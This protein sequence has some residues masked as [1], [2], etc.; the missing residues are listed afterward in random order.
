MINFKLTVDMNVQSQLIVFTLDSGHLIMDYFEL[1]YFANKLEFSVEKYPLQPD[2]N[3]SINVIAEKDAYVALQAIEQRDLL[4]R[5]EGF[6]ITKAHVLEDLNEYTPD[7]YLIESDPIYYFGLFVR[8]SSNTH[9]EPS[10]TKRSTQRTRCQPSVKHTLSEIDYPESW[11]WKI[12]TMNNQSKLIISEVMPKTITSWFVTGFALSPTRGL[13]LMNA[14]TKLTVSKPFLI[15]AN[16]PY[17]IE[18]FEVVRIQVTLFN[19]L[20]DPL[21]TNVTLYNEC[22][23]F[24]FVDRTSSRAKILVKQAIVK[25]YDHP[26]I[27]SF[28]IK[29]KKLGDITIKIEAA[30]H[31]RTDELKHILR[32]T[33][34]NLLEKFSQTELI[35]L[36]SYATQNFTM[37]IKIPK[38]AEQESVKIR[39]MIDPLCADIPTQNLDS[40]FVIPSSTASSNLLNI[41]P[42]V[43]V[44]DYN[45]EKNINDSFIEQEAKD[46]LFTGYTNQLKYKHSNGAFGQWDPPQKEP[47]IFLTALVA[48]AFGMASKHIEIDQTVITKAFSWINE[49]QKWDGCF[50]EDGEIIYE[51]MQNSASS[52]ALTAFIITAIMENNSTAIQFSELVEEATNCLVN[53]FDLLTNAHDIALATYALSLTG[54]ANR[55]N[56][57]NTLIEKVFDETGG[58]QNVELSVETA[59][60]TLLSFLAQHM[61]R[62]TFLTMMW[63]NEQRYST[64]AF[65]GVHSTLVALKA[66]GQFAVYLN[67]IQNDFLVHV[68]YG[69]HH[70]SFKIEQSSTVESI[71]LPGDTRLIDVEISGIGFG[72]VQL[73]YQYH[74]NYS[75]IKKVSFNLD[76]SVLDTSTFEIQNLQVCFSYIPTESNKS[77]RIVRVEVYLPSGFIVNENALKDRNR[78][79]KKIERVFNNTAMFVYYTEVSANREC[80]E[81]TAHQKYQIALH[82]A[83]YVVVQ[84]YYDKSKYVIKSY[85]GKV[86]ESFPTCVRSDFKS[87]LLAI[88]GQN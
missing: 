71:E 39:V 87:K 19:F 41:I 74:F 60:Y 88:I 18:R 12:Y 72:S 65:S 26:S 44:L 56:Y 43:F 49:K 79:I 2:E 58:Y 15:I 30:S 23:E 54:H 67:R 42:K 76:V 55:R 10:R 61:Y 31:L 46:D 48:N 24:Q 3:V 29:A 28:L 73:D 52:F 59:G 34:E 27:V 21:P 50:E 25:Q 36:D 64:G 20:T 37:G 38:N 57:L 6:G 81:V 8:A 22:D 35:N 68:R 45:K 77:L 63:L 47:S 32:V 17:S 80:F 70:Q 33:P 40:L 86:V 83:S 11:L 78:R 62:D 14:P 5:H 1:D 75:S 53:N 84:D 69:N 16:L 13:G 51:P 4:L 7:H 85:E 66:L 82:R 9:D